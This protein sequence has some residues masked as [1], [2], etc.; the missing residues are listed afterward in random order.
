MAHHAAHGGVVNIGNFGNMG[1]VRNMSNIG[2]LGEVRRMGNMGKLGKLGKLG[3]IGKSTSPKKKS[4]CRA[5]RAQKYCRRPCCPCKE[6]FFKH[7][8]SHTHRH[9]VP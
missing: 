4:A 7:D 1:E 6:F 5:Q 2:K 9:G 8:I 3:G